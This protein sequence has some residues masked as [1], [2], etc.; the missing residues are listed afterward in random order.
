M[1]NPMTPAAADRVPS[2]ITR[3]QR[4]TQHAKQYTIASGSGDRLMDNQDYD[5]ARK[6]PANLYDIYHCCVYSEKFLMMDRG[7]V[8]N[9]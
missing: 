8:R 7:T 1:K 5:P 2:V 6:L 3:M 4:L 9:M